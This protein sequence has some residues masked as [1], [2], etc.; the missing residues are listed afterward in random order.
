M[1]Q[2]NLIIILLLL[3]CIVHLQLKNL[4]D[5]N[6]KKPV[7]L[8]KALLSE[9]KYFPI[10][11]SSKEREYVTFN[12]SY[13]ASRTYGGERL[14]E[15]CDIMALENKSEV[16]PVVSICDGTIEQLGWLEL[17]GY[18]VGIRSKNGY[19]YYYA[20]LS[21]YAEGLAEGQTI[22]AGELLGFMGDSGY[23]E[24]GTTGKFDVH[25]HFGIYDKTEQDV[26][27][28]PYPYLEKLSKQKLEYAY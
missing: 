6:N 4:F 26:S 14:H 20:H 19:Y 28:N 22:Y 25:L 8:E 17:G 13:G 18:R 9:M 1:K 3:C 15:G 24:E 11:S 7:I 21:S 12:D 2:L 16:Y 5:K 27:L 10:P 23:G